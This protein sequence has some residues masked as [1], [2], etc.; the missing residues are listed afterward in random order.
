MGSS[1]SR[2]GY[3]FTE[4]DAVKSAMAYLSVRGYVV[5]KAAA[6]YNAFNDSYFYF[7]LNG[8]GWYRCTFEV[9]GG[10][11]VCSLTYA[12]ASDEELTDRFKDYVIEIRGRKASGGPD[13]KQD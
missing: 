9:V 1:F 3:G 2:I 8:Y 13:C 12:L 6:V 7:K 4:D 11:Q 5:E 10:A